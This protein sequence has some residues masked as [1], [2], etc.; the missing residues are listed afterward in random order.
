MALLSDIQ[1]SLLQE[2]APIA[3][4]LLKFKFLAARLQSHPLQMWITNELEGYPGGSEV[5]E[6]R[7]LE[8]VYHGTFSGP[9]GSGIKNAPIPSYLIKQCA[10]EHWNTY[11]MRQS[12][13]AV[14]DLIKSSDGNGTLHVNASNLMLLLQGKVYPDYACNEVTG[15]CSVSQLAE[16]QHAVRGRLLD[17][18]LEFENVPG[19]EEIEIGSGASSNLSG[20]SHTVT[21]IF[22]QTVHGTMQNVNNTGSVGTINFNGPKGD[23]DALVAFLTSHGLAPGD[24]QEFSEILKSEEPENKTEPFGKKAKAWIADNLK[25]AVDGTWKAGIGAATQV[26][27]KGALAYYGLT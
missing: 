27:T 5:P 17:L 18:A 25:K 4:V 13:A 26:L 20:S 7:K 24:A 23:A 9:F 16:L 6:Y 12:I 15:S 21:Q 19:A 2:N 10:G 1:T 22:H 3:P 8:L 11:E 14:D